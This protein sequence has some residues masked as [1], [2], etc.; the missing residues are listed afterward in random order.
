MLVYFEIKYLEYYIYNQERLGM[1]LG[2]GFWPTPTQSMN[3]SAARMWQPSCHTATTLWT[4]CVA[5]LV[6]DTMLAG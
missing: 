3:N 6:T 1:V 5:T 4:W 2:R